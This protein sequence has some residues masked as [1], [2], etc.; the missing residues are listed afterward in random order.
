MWLDWF[1][2]RLFIKKL[3]EGGDR[4]QAVARAM[5]PLRTRVVWQFLILNTTVDWPQFQ[6]YTLEKNCPWVWSELHQRHR[7]T[8]NFH[9]R[10]TS[11]LHLNLHLSPWASS[12]SLPF[13][14]YIYIF[15]HLY[16]S[17]HSHYS[18]CHLPKPSQTLDRLALPLQLSH[19]L[20]AKVQWLVIKR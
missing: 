13:R 2:K 19:S 11:C 10:P 16:H 5:L 18:Q 8:W 14:L 1:L 9:G 20:P 4:D 17:P 15:H 6:W 12:S 7:A 3:P